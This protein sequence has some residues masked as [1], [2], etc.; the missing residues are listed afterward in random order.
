VIPSV[1][2]FCV[3]ARTDSLLVFPVRSATID[4]SKATKLRDLTFRPESL[5]IKWIVTTFQTT[6]SKHQELRK[7]SISVP[8]DLVF[9]DD[10]DAVKRSATFG[11][12]RDLDHLLVQFWESHPTRP[13]VVCTTWEGWQGGM[14]GFNECFFPE[15]T[16]RGAID[17]E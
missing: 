16:R 10:V 9:I 5:N 17:V 2:P 12:W 7:V 6:T 4:L 1:R 13:K 8:D 14:R 15:L 11:G 3:C